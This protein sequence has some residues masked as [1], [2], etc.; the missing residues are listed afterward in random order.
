MAQHRALGQPVADDAYASQ[1]SFAIKLT[2]G[3]RLV[4]G[5]TQRMTVGGA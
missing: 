1:E 3:V 4:T 5:R 2:R